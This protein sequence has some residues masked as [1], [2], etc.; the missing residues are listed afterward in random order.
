MWG[1]PGA[2][3]FL[4]A[5]FVWQRLG[6]FG[7]VDAALNA[8]G[9]LELLIVPPR[10]IVPQV[11]LPGLLRRHGGGEGGSA[12]AQGSGEG[13]RQREEVQVLNA[14]LASAGQPSCV[15]A[16]VCCSC[17]CNASVAKQSEQ[18]GVQGALMGTVVSRLYA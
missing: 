1:R 4:G 6:C 14:C 11:A 2:L 18:A 10:S 5:A 16:L 17:M 13:G 12:E 3:L 7:P 9:V 15:A 8:P